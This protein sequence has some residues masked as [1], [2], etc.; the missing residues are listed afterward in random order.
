MVSRK[1]KL[2]T[3]RQ[4]AQREGITLQTAYRRIWQRQVPAR[5]R[6]GRWLISAP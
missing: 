2:L 1:L 4:Y 3:V 6:Y 5:R